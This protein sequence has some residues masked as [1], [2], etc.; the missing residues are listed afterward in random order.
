MPDPLSLAATRRRARLSRTVELNH[1]VHGPADAPA[2]LLGGSIGTT[3]RMWQPQIEELSR[4]FRVV[5][6]DTRGHGQSP[7]AAGPTRM[8]DLAADVVALADRIRVTRFGYCGLSIGGAIGQVLAAQHADRV[9]AL[10]LCCTAARFGNPTSWH[11]RAQ[12]VRREGMAWL[13]EPTRGRWFADGFGDRQPEE[14]QRLLS[15][16]EATDPDGYAA[17]CDALAAY[18]GGE[19]LPNITAPTLVIAGADDPATP[20]TSSEELA[21]GIPDAELTVVPRASHLVTAERP[22]VVTPLIRSHMERH[23]T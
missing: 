13:V 15:M 4:T 18:D 23:L 7:A 9:A 22:D 5:A 10:V 8:E 2:I 12:R 11:E 19:H 17:C 16:V 21:A 6:F 20:I 3:W 14:A 1:A